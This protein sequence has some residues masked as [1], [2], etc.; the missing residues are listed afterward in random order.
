[1]SKRKQEN[2]DEGDGHDDTLEHP[3][4]VVHTQRVVFGGGVLAFVVAHAPII[5][6]WGA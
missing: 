1:M 5:H 4:Q 2:N 3:K 6:T